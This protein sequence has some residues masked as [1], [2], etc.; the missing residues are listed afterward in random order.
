MTIKQKGGIF[1]RNPTFNDVTVEG[2]FNLTTASFDNLAVDTDTL[3]VDAANDRVGINLN[4]PVSELHIKDPNS[5]VSDAQ[6][7]IEGRQSAYGA[8]I[9]FQSPLGTSGSLKEMARITADGEDAW[10]S[11]D[12]ASQDSGLRFF[13][14][15]NGVTTEKVRINATGNIVVNSGNGIDF[16]ATAGTGTSE[17]LSDYEEGTFTL[18]FS[19]SGSGGNTTGT[20]VYTKVGNKV[21]VHATIDNINTTGLTAGNKAHVYGFPFAATSAQDVIGNVWFSGGVTTSGSCFL[22]IQNGATYARFFE[23]PYAG[24]G[25]ILNVSAFTDDAADL[26]INATYIVS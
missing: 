10:T 5:A 13:T 6:I 2:S 15:L 25:D 19:D 4:N 24:T 20:G 17:L 1:G 14:T 9:S 23:S 3:Y 12:S 22:Y 16:S 21:T 18:T 11:T 7:T 8:G 26:N